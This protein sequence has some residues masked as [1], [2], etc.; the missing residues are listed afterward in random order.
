MKTDLKLSGLDFLRMEVASYVEGGDGHFSNPQSMPDG[1]FSGKYLTS[2]G[3]K[4]LD[5]T[6]LDYL[7]LGMS[8][9]VRKIMMESVRDFDLACPASQMVMRCGSTVKL[10]QAV[11]ELHGMGESLIFTAG[12]PANENVIQGLGLR[13]MTPHLLPYIRGEKLGDTSRAI[14]TIFFV[15][16]ETHFSLSHGIKMAK[17]QAGKNRCMSERFPSGDY[18][19]LLELLEE[20]QHMYGDLAVRVIVSDTLSSTTGKVFDVG[21]LYEIAEEYDCLLYLD[22]AHAIGCMGPEGR[23]IAASVPNYGHF[24]DRTL[25][26]GTL[27]KAISQLG[28]YVTVADPNLAC[29]LRSASPQYIFSAPIPP[30]M[31]EATVKILALV[32]GSYG[33]QKR[34]RL[35][36]VALRMRRL[37][38]EEGFNILG[39]KSHIV[40]VFVGDDEKNIRTKAF[41]E[42]NGFMPA[43]FIYPAVPR[44]GSSIRFS[45]CADITDD[46]V[47][48]L[49]GTLVR[50]RRSIN[51]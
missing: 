43:M 6:R 50:A 23:G 4:I 29:F 1:D 38:E 10:E 37:L 5:L 18:D 51:F 42:R 17:L 45:L 34:V 35:A 40:S 36:A 39:S 11:A 41:L 13:L 46:E 3:K 25:I 12:Y 49:V 14:P 9:E 31:A 30:W 22:E 16:E 8:D 19:R 21:A 7:S 28:G 44:G 26:M 24:R 27:T 48:A 32:K 20:S 47:D 33:E 2:N 15:D